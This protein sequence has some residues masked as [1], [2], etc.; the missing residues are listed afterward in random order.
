METEL[1]IE[2]L[3]SCLS[4]L[5]KIDNLPSLIGCILRSIGNADSLTFFIFGSSN[6][7]DLVVS[8]ID[9]LFTSELEDL[10]PTRISAPD[11]HVCGSSRALDIP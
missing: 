3:G 8:W 1:L 6:I 7:K 5:I 2:S 9:K 10:E 11:L 4:S